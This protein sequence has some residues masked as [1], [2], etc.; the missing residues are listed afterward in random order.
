VLI[1]L[2]MQIL[3][4]GIRQYRMAVELGWDPTKLSRII[5]EAIEPSAEERRAIA[6]YLKVSESEIFSEEQ[7]T[8]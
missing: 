7:V 2:K 5:Q 4:R 8:A 1:P 6:Q 3:T